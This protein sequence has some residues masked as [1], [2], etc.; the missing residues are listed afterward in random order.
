MET[1]R[2]QPMKEGYSPELFEKLYKETKNLRRSLVNQID[3]RRYNVTPDIMESWFDDKFIYV[4][5]KYFDQHEPDVLKGHIINAL[6]T[7]KLRVLR[8]AYSAEGIF[9]TNTVELEGESELINIIPDKSLMPVE[10]VF[11]DT[12]IEFMKN[13]LSDNAYLLLEIQLNPPPYILD[14]IT[15]HNSRIPNELLAEYLGLFTDKDLR[16][17]KNLKREISKATKSARE[18]FEYNPLALQY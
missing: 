2:L 6:R 14:K 15:K 10:T 8:K 9:H 3:C 13:H 12:A 17:L 11:Y 1:H 16:L 7:F 4:F 18:Y 5:N